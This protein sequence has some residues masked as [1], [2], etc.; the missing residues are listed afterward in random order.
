MT[1]QTA[2]AKEGAGFQDGDDGQL[3]ARGNDAELHFA[4]AD[5]EQSIGGIGLR[6]NGRA[7]SVV[8]D[9][10]AGPRSGQ[11]S[12]DVQRRLLGGTGDTH[13]GRDGAFELFADAAGES[14]VGKG[15]ARTAGLFRNVPDAP[16]GAQYTGIRSCLHFR[17]VHRSAVGDSAIQAVDGIMRMD[18]LLQ[19]ASR[20]HG[21]L[22]VF[23]HLGAF[24][25][26]FLAILDSSPV[27]TFGG[28]DIL[29]AILVS[30]HRL[31]WYEYAVVAAAG[32]TIGAFLTFRLARKAG[33][34]YLDSKFGQARVS[35]LLGIFQ[36]WGT[37]TLV[38]SSAIPFPF[39]TSLVFAAAGAS[40]YRLGKYLAVV[41]ISR[42]VRYSTI[43]L[44][45]ERYGR[46]LVR[47]VAHPTQYWGWL[48][49]CAAVIAILIGGG[50]V[51]N[52]RLAAAP[53]N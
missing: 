5:V 53:A 10:Q 28:P 46:P 30:T 14:S 20:G 41:A 15:V 21:F 22:A 36:K 29:I 35:R 37:G 49:L 8:L 31:P 7:S 24:G 33:E 1:R 47:A 52:R 25:L 16:A 19:T 43:A 13:G 40:D 2:F 38:A 27:P 6:K 34:V 17:V 32:S 9:R 11:K 51:V 44:L 39:P 50:V 4:L 42:G 3:A 18:M 26:F 23:R 48:L 12:K 45:V